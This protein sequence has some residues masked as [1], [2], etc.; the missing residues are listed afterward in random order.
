M[1]DRCDAIEIKV[2]LFEWRHN[3]GMRMWKGPASWKVINS[4]ILEITEHVHVTLVV[5]PSVKGSSGK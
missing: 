3:D 2:E 4:L 5:K 1:I